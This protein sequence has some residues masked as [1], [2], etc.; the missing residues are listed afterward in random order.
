MRS[1][2]STV[3]KRTT[4]GD[5]RARAQKRGETGLGDGGEDDSPARVRRSCCLCVCVCYVPLWASH[6]RPLR[7]PMTS[8]SLHPRPRC[9]QH[10]HTSS[11]L[12]PRPH[13]GRFLPPIATPAAA[14]GLATTTTMTAPPTP[15]VPPT[16]PCVR[17]HHAIPLSLAMKSL[18][19]RVRKLATLKEWHH[20]WPGSLVLLW[21]LSLL[22]AWQ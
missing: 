6:R 7:R 5:A 4:I 18:L 8:S 21:P 10:Q 11:L 22:P 16:T 17:G 15:A 12:R 9:L 2:V 1:C 3:K 19:L 14:A 13:A 20:S